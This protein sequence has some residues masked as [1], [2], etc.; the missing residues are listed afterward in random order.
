M[1]DKCQ[2]SNSQS[3]SLVNVSQQGRTEEAG[4]LMAQN[5]LEF[6]SLYRKCFEADGRR[7]PEAVESWPTARLTWRRPGS[8]KIPGSFTLPG[9]RS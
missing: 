7:P 5:V 3:R 1:F 9:D 6:K 8:L 4:I 2:L